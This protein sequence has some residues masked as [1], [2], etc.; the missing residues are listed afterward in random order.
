MDCYENDGSLAWCYT[1][2]ICLQIKKA[3]LSYDMNVFFKDLYLIF[4]KQ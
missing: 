1:A 2:S 3:K 4:Q